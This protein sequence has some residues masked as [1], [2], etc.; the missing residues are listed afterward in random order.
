MKISK[1]DVFVSRAKETYEKVDGF[2]VGAYVP[3]RQVILSL[4]T[5]PLTRMIEMTP[6]EAEE[7][8]QC[9]INGAKDAREKAQA[10]RILREQADE[11]AARE[12]RAQQSRD[13][14]QSGE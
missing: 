9:L 12:I 3:G 11:D 1:A 5:H 10:A 2:S 8:A 6:E 7:L 13:R 4:F 14:T